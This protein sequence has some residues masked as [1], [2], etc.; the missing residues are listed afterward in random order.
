MIENWEYLNTKEILEENIDSCF[1][2]IKVL[3]DEDFKAYVFDLT[4]EK[5]KNIRN[6][7]TENDYLIIINFEEWEKD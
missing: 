5:S 6:I 3:N 2:Y 4:D 7:F 1:E